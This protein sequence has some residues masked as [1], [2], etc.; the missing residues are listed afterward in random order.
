MNA[1]LS[2]PLALVPASMPQEVDIPY[3]KLTLEN[4]LQVVVHEDHSDPVVAVYVVYH[5]GSARE[6]PGRS[7]FAHLFEHIMFQGSLHVGD[8]EHFKRISEA[9]G[10]LNGTTNTDRTNYFET[11]PSNQLELAL[12]LEA[13]RMG[14]LLPAVT[15]EKLDRQRDVVKNE[16]RQNYENRPYG[17]VRGAVAAALYPPD[18]PY[19]WLTIGSHEDLSAASLEDVHAFFR[20]WYGPNNATLAIG[21]DVDPEAVRALVTKWFGAIPR[22][23]DVAKPAPR[24]A[25]LERSK[26]LVIEDKVQLP[27]LTITWPT[28]PAEH[29]DEAAL[30]LLG[31]I[32]S[33]NKSAVLDRALT[34][35]A[36]LAKDVSAFHDALELA[37]TFTITL[38]PAKGV[39]LDELE[40]RTQELLRGLAE[41]GVDAEHLQRVKNSY[42]AGFVRRLETVSARTNALAEYNCYLGE[43]GG[44]R[45]D[46]ARR[47]AVTPEDVRRVLERYLI[48]KPAV[49]VSVVPEGRL[50]L[51][52]SA[53]PPPVVEARPDP[54]RTHAPE[55]GPAPAFHAPTVWHDRQPSGVAITGTRYT[56]LP[57]TR[58]E[59]SVPAGRVHERPETL[60]LA[61]LCADMLMEGTTTLSST[62][63]AEALEGIGATLDARADD[64]EIS[65]SLSCLDKHLERAVGLLGDVLLRP[66]F[67]ED[68]F[69]RVRK[70]R[71]I[72]IETRADR[73]G[74]VAADVFQKLVRGDGVLGAA[75]VGTRATVEALDVDD[76][77]AFWSAH[78]VP[79]GA[80]LCYA[81]GVRELFGP[82]LAAW[83]ERPVAARPQGEARPASYGAP[84][85]TGRIYL[86]DKPG[87]AQSEIRIGHRSLASTDPDFYPLFVLNYVLGGNFSSR[88][89]LNLREDK[90]WA[91]GARSSL[92]GGLRPG[93]FVAS[94]G[95]QTDHTAEAV[96]EFLKEIEG[97]Q[98]GVSG[99]E[100]AFAQSAL[101]QAATRQ[102]ESMRAQI[103]MLDNISRYGWP[104]DYVEERIRTTRGLDRDRLLELARAYI[105]PD[106]L[107]VLVVGDRERVLAG[108]KAL[109]LGPVVELGT[110]GSSLE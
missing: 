42:E 23:P 56:E 40:R 100:L 8:D 27:Q 68:D 63:L 38:R 76:V 28:V 66:R 72:D 110:D 95:I 10:T 49:F 14:F 77:R 104:D 64:D 84:A 41:S 91:Y 34:V 105:H 35:D 52:L 106:E 50:E 48:D 86:V 97:I 25:H 53:P 9:G 80:R 88:I 21:G 37:G 58:L 44:F 73:I 75:S 20:R 19:S 90:G 65:L 57:M 74:T 109:E 4:G 92:E 32:L 54:A 16:R 43:P 22:G 60:G 7:G 107:I 67:A 55:P 13:D 29:A 94:G 101:E 98:G 108:L 2:I 18:H 47:L 61:S 12:W 70:Q 71:L 51:A 102:Y 24:P 62:E 99:D 103:A 17:R 85:P 30:D 33:A 59:L 69:A 83:A 45:Q 3:Q 36:T 26:R 89:N 79:Q 5:V 15:Q 96:A 82:I 31:R 46:L 39:K 1:L 87:A 81:A 93:A 6:E 11:L 78:A